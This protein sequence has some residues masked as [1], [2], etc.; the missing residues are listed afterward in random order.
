MIKKFY[1]LSKTQDASISYNPFFYFL[2][3]LLGNTLLAYCPIEFSLKIWLGIMLILLPLFLAFV[4]VQDKPH[5]EK[6]VPVDEFLPNPPLLFWLL[7]AGGA[8]F[9][10]FFQLV[11]LPAWPMWDDAL[12][13][14]F[15]I[16]LMEHWH[17]QLWFTAETLPPFVFWM[18]A[19]FLKI[20]PPSLFSIWLLS[21]LQSSLVLPISY[22]ALR[23]FLSKSLSILYLVIL[24]F[25]FWTLYLGRFWY[26]LQSI[27]LWQFLAIG[28]WGRYLR[29][30]ESGQVN[31]SVFYLGIC[32]GLG[33]YTSILT[34]PLICVIWLGVLLNCW[35]RK[36]EGAKT[37]FVFLITLMA[38]LTPLFQQIC[39][40]LLN[41]HVFKYSVLSRAASIPEQ[42]QCSLSY[43]TVFLWGTLNKSYFNFGPLWGGYLNP[44]L[45]STLLIGLVELFQMNRKNFCWFLGALTICVLPGIFSNTLEMIRVISVLPLS[46][47]LIVLGLR[48]LFLSAHTS[49]K[50]L[51]LVLLLFFSLSL[52]VYHLW[53][54]CHQWAVPNKD[55]G[56]SKS[57]E[58]YQA[59]QILEKLHQIKGPGLVL[60]DFYYDVFDQSLF[61]TT[62]EYNAAANPRL[63]LTQAQWA[64][65]P[66]APWDVEIFKKRFPSAA[67][68]DISNG[69]YRGNHDGM[70]MAVVPLKGEEGRI[71]RGWV[72]I[73][74]QIQELFSDY[75]FHVQNPSYRKVLESLWR[76]YDQTPQEPFL[77]NC[78]M[79]KIIYSAYQSSDLNGAEPLAQLPE[80]QLWHP[81]FF[82]R[83]YAVVFN[84]LGLLHMRLGQYAEA[85]KLFLRAAKFDPQ[86]PLY[87]ALALL[88]K[89]SH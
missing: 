69:L 13:S 71:L 87:K 33:P 50:M 39:S 62:Y 65:I 57:P 6:P 35:K 60:S 31:K 42:L 82:N 77:K 18:Q 49:Q 64:A 24:A 16:H 59:F 27:I 52:D 21:A 41:G 5:K 63:D 54:P 14:Y 81:R 4:S 66:M 9:L 68:Y 73:H 74:N 80:S 11:E 85:R 28:F 25:G 2:I 3:F 12:T 36:T 7:L 26:E 84:K 88:N 61:V 72:G 30:H 8:L 29:S 23:Q 43:L 10:R 20:C 83:C 15:S 70:Q 56:G 51:I 45:G 75:P 1:F 46:I 37:F 86:F 40:N 78:L 34:S 48:K 38:T 47:F 76:I 55:S 67:M 89:N 44:L 19:L 32:L 22:W 79:E 58:H 17:W 53:G